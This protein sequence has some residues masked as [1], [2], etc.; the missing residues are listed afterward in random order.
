MP[1]LAALLFACIYAWHGNGGGRTYSNC[2][3]DRVISAIHTSA[4]VG[5][6]FLTKARWHLGEPGLVGVRGKGPGLGGGVV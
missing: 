4:R 3:S 6:V 1:L 5:R 2:S